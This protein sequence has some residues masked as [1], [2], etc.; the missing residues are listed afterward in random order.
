MSEKLDRNLLKM[1]DVICPNQTEVRQNR[2]V[3]C[4]KYL[5]WFQAELL[6]DRSVE[7]IEDAKD[8]CKKLLELGSRIA[9][10]TMGEQGAVIL[11]ESGQCEHVKIE[12]CSSV[13]DSTGAGDSFVGTLALL[14][15]SEKKLTLK[16]QVKR[17]CRVASQSVEK[18][19]TQTS[20][21]SRNELR[22][23]LFE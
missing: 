7:T 15:A 14:M 9:I 23:N 10:I 2:E 11:D 8:A 6:C 12:K 19:G 18:K 22:F 21:P 3:L 1:A 20:Y 5:P 4:V 13:C 17:A 16:E